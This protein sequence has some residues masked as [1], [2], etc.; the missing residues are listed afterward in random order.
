MGWLL[1]SREAYV[2]RLPVA[3]LASVV[4]RDIGS[5]ENTLPGSS[6]SPAELTA[7]PANAADGVPATSRAQNKAMIRLLHFPACA[8]VLASPFFT[9]T[10]RSSS[11]R[12]QGSRRSKRSSWPLRR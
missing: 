10:T 12:N 3:T 4:E 8:P 1:E 6:P 9:S 5:T 7:P 11:W 2:I